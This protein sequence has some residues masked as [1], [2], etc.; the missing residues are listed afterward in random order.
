MLNQTPW[1]E[2]HRR[3]TGQLE[4]GAVMEHAVGYQRIAERFGVPRDNH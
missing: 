4:T 1:Q 3:F 2:I